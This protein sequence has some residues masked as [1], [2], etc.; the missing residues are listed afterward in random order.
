MRFK[1]S[2]LKMEATESFFS[3]V[4]NLSSSAKQ[5]TSKQAALLSAA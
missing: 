3:R 5:E 2:L 4:M 1:L